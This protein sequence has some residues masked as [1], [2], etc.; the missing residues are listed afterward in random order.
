MK[1]TLTYL[2]LG[3]ALIGVSTQAC[4]ESTNPSAPLRGG[5][6]QGN[7][8]PMTPGGSA[9]ANMRGAFRT[10]PGG[11]V[12]P[13]LNTRPDP[14]QT[15]SSLEQ[16]GFD[17]SL[18]RRFDGGLDRSSVGTFGGNRVGTFGGNANA[19]RR[20]PSTGT[21]RPG[22]G[23]PGG[24]NLSGGSASAMFRPGATAIGE[25]N[26]GGAAR[27]AFQGNAQFQGDAQVN[28]G[29][30]ADARVNDAAVV[31]A[32]TANAAGAA[33][34]AAARVAPLAPPSENAAIAPI[35]PATEVAPLAPAVPVGPLPP[36]GGVADPRPAVVPDVTR[37]AVPAADWARATAVPGSNTVVVTT[38]RTE[39]A[40]MRIRPTEPLPT[41]SERI[42]RSIP[43]TTNYRGPI[44]SAPYTYWD[45]YYWYL[46]PASGWHYWDGG[47]W[48]LFRNRST[49]L[50]E[51]AQ[52]LSR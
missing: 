16:R 35:A 13:S 34:E 30:A 4:G 37:G 24:A 42:D 51:R 44:H 11:N 36:S 38:D 39:P 3:M 6:N 9:A 8:S 12:D 29:V 1:R 49:N 17:S 14:R 31:N 27:A 41:L 43:F 23:I 22:S 45:G 19:F 15:D 25:A 20:G 21:I 18:N 52:V 48:L 50:D 26:I 32:L 7:S 10:G 33:L 28:P 2:T 47:R 40:D 5:A 46:S